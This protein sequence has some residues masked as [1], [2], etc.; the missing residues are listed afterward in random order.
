VAIMGNTPINANPNALNTAK[1][2]AIRA[3]SRTLRLK[4]TK[5]LYLRE[6]LA[7]LSDDDDCIN[8]DDFKEGLKQAK[9]IK[10]REVDVFDLLFTMWDCEGEDKIPFKDLVVGIAPLAC[11]EEDLGKILQF[12]M[13]VSDEDKRGTIG[14]V[15]LE[16]V[17]YSKL[18]GVESDRNN[19][20]IALFSIIYSFLSIR[21]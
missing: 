4:K 19:Q 18:H 5:V 7:S 9:F 20:L 11:P 14:R 17:L 2:L 3:V 6:V 16:D 1:P 21:P 12:A 15:E 8:Y 10:S 13:I